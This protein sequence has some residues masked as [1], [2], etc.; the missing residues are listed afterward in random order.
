MMKA[1]ILRQPQKGLV[2]L[3]GRGPQYTSKYYRK[4][5]ANYGMTA[6]SSD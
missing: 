3:S 1:Y 6:T 2:F 5:L 4:L